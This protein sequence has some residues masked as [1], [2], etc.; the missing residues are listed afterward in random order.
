MFKIGRNNPLPQQASSELQNPNRKKPFNSRR[1]INE[2]VYQETK[3]NAEQSNLANQPLSLNKHS[4]EPIERVRLDNLRTDDSEMIGA[5]KKLDSCFPETMREFHKASQFA[6]D[7]RRVPGSGW[8]EEEVLR[9]NEPDLCKSNG[10]IR[11]SKVLSLSNPLKSTEALIEFLERESANLHFELG[12]VKKIAE[13]VSARLEKTEF[14]RLL[15]KGKVSFERVGWRTGGE[16]KYYFII[17]D[18]KIKGSFSSFQIGHS[19]RGSPRAITIEEKN[20]DMVLF[21]EEIKRLE[22]RRVI[23]NQNL[24]LVKRLTKENAPNVCRMMN[25]EDGIK[26]SR[27]G[28]MN[29]HQG[30]KKWTKMQRLNLYRSLFKGLFQ[31][32]SVGLCH[33]DLKC[34]NVV[35]HINEQQE[36]VAWIIDILDFLEEEGMNRLGTAMIGTRC[37]WS[38]DHVAA[39]QKEQLQM[40]RPVEDREPVALANPKDDVWAA[41]LMI[42]QL[43]DL[44]S[45][46][47]QEDSML[48]PEFI[49]IFVEYRQKVMHL[50]SKRE[51]YISF[52]DYFKLHPDNLFDAGRASVTD[53]PLDHLVYQ[54]AS[55]RSEQRLSSKQVL[56]RFPE[57]ADSLRIDVPGSLRTSLCQ[58]PELYSQKSP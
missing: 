29:I 47:S 46:V 31:M 54:M 19:R 41:M 36:P 38:P 48:S 9:S 53:Y 4:F 22:E 55:T 7:C 1:A 21:P 34:R 35:V 14:C 27:L 24:E 33:R 30:V 23:R 11:P 50:H 45:Q 10:K 28:D 5:P 49:Q 16:D 58:I 39:Y 25:Y 32:H 40:G 3:D 2:S 37:M 15:T 8:I 18:S 52:Q 13:D 56:E 51:F 42:C 43:E 20:E 6:Q 17:R 12:A 44:V 26:V 57:H